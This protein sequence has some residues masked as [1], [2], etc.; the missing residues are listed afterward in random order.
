M[1]FKKMFKIKIL[2]LLLFVAF[3]IPVKSIAEVNASMLPS[4]TTASAKMLSRLT[5]IQ[6]LDK[7]NL[8]STEKKDL[9]NELREMKHQAAGH[10][11]GKGIY[12]S[13]GAIIIIILLL[14]LLL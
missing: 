10:G 13:F 2:L 1:T 3:A 9:R 12:L 5:D 4:D 11:N 6:H 8:T 14:I 7:S